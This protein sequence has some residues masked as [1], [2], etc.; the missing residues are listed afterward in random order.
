VSLLLEPSA[1]DALRADC[2]A[3]VAAGAEHVHLGV[4]PGDP[5]T[6]DRLADALDLIM[7]P[8]R[9]WPWARGVRFFLDLP[10]PVTDI[11]RWHRALG[12]HTV[13]VTDTRG[14]L[15]PWAPAGPTFGFVR[16]SLPAVTLPPDGTV[17]VEFPPAA[18][19]PL[20]VPGGAWGAQ[21]LSPAHVEAADA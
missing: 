21:P 16:D 6:H 5:E 10:G 7:G 20:V 17:P 15:I 18:A 1:R 4:A 2:A 19:R 14:R 9:R 8:F 3:L 13:E 11:P 12:G